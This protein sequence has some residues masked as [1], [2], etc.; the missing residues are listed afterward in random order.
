MA[1]FFSL[2][3]LITGAPR[4]RTESFKALH[5]EQMHCRTDALVFGWKRNVDGLACSQGD[6][7][8][9]EF[10]GRSRYDALVAAGEV[11]VEG[12][13]AEEGTQASL[14]AFERFLNPARQVSIDPPRW[15]KRRLPVRYIPKRTPWDSGN[16]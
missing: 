10:P 15:H 16:S 14:R 6:A 13:V 3:C 2:A 1:D 9:A 8:R 11:T 12:E 5:C 4:V 7:D